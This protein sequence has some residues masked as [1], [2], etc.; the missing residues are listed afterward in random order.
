M[1][2]GLVDVQGPRLLL[3]VLEPKD[4]C[5]RGYCVLWLRLSLMTNSFPFIRMERK[6]V[7]EELRRN[8]FLK[9]LI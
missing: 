2:L 9:D 3:V 6:S 1:C 7:L 5:D 8:L 4:L